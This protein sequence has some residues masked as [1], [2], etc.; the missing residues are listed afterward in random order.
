MSYLD[1]EEQRADAQGGVVNGQAYRYVKRKATP[2]RKSK[3][4]YLT[5]PYMKK[6]DRLIL[7]I[8][9]AEDCSAPEAFERIIDLAMV[10][11]GVK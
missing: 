4:F 11:Y 9:Q 1:K 5:Q 6:T 2:P 10:R 3:A 7:A 8:R